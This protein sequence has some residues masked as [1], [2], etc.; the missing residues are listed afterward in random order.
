MIYIPQT[1]FA[2]ILS[3]GPLYWG[4]GDAPSDPFV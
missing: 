4:L 1:D 3:V 2:F